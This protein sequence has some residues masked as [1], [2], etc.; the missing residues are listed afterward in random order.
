MGLL[1]EFLPVVRDF[2]LIGAEI[3]LFQL[4][5]TKARQT[6]ED[7]LACGFQSVRAKVNKSKTAHRSSARIIAERRERESP[8]LPQ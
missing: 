8:C 5:L 4:A 7:L 1:A 3:C 6:R 2:N